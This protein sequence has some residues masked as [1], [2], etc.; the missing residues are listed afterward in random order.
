MTKS[1]VAVCAVDVLGRFFHESPSERARAAVERGA[2]SL[3]AGLSPDAVVA[4]VEE[5]MS[6]L[7][8]LTGRTVSEDVT[9]RI[10]ERFCV[11][12]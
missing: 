7:G 5:A 6:A 8:E 2:Q 12:K 1:A 9:A 3:K 10:F 11:G 4:D